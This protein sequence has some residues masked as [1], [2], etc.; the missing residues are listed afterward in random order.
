MSHNVFSPDHERY[1]L[2]SMPPGS[3][4]AYTFQQPGAYTQLCNLHPE[5]LAYVFVGQNPYMS[6]VHADGSFSIQGV[7]AGNYEIAVWNSHL[8]GADQS[9]SVTP[10]QT[11]NVTFSIHR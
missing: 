6:V 5:M 9:V 8:K 3:E 1:D 2:G 7:P 10:D 4:K 11:S